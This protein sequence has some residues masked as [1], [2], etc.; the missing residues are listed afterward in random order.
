M[1]NSATVNDARARTVVFEL[2]VLSPRRTVMRYA[3]SVVRPFGHD[4][5][6]KPRR[7][8]LSC[9]MHLAVHRN[10]PLRVG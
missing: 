4:C 5:S 6:G 8:A 2:A 3:S 1:P 10:G 7:S 9:G